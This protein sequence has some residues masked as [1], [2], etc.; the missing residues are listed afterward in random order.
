M[1]S[2][3]SKVITVSYMIAGAL[4]GIVINVLLETLSAMATG[5]AARILGN[6]Y[7]R[8]GTPVI[9]GLATFAILQFNGRINLW[10][11]DVVTELRRV[12]FPSRTDVTRMTLVVCVMLIISGLAIGLLDV[13][14]AHLIDFILNFNMSRYI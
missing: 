8:H 9:V 4:M 13:V 14:S 5:P 10:A 11:E 7:I 1:E 12:V 6:E 3:N 2:T